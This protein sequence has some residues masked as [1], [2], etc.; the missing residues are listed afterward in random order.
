MTTIVGIRVPSEDGGIVIAPDIQKSIE[1]REDAEIE[2]CG[3]HDDCGQ[4]F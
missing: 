2:E 3:I 4:S 1:N